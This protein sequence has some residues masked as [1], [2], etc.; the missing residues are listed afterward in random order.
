ML[1]NSDEEKF[2]SRNYLNTYGNLETL[3]SQTG[4]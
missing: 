3:I 2:D 1:G 4:I